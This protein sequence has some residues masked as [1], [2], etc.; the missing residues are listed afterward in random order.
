MHENDAGS[1]LSYFHLTKSSRSYKIMGFRAETPIASRYSTVMTSPDVSLKERYEQDGFVII[2]DLIPSGDRVGL[3]EAC[4][5]VI[6]RTRS[7]SWV[8]RRV[9][10]FETSAS[11]G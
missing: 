11:L 7:G 6:A 9:A 5:R 10:S 8:Q 1:A 4:E 3:E 2:P